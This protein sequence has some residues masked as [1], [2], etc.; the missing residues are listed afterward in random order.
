MARGIPEEQ[1]RRLVIRG[2]FSEIVS[3]LQL[4]EIEDRIMERIDFE[5]NSV[6]L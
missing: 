3:K 2:F 5:L 6:T 4:P 1:A